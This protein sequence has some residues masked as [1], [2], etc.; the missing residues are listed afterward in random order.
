MDETDKDMK[1]FEITYVL[2]RR[3]IIR[4]KNTEEAWGIAED[5]RLLHERISTI[6]ELGVERERRNAP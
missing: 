5:H 3:A 6:D 2:Y 1:H 4:A